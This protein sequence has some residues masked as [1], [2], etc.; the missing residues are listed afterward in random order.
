MKKVKMLKTAC[1][2]HGSFNS[3]KEY[4]IDDD[5]AKAWSESQDPACLII[6]V[7]KNEEEAPAPAPEPEPAPAPEP[8]PEPAPAPTP[9]RGKYRPGSK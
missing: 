1:G 4:S 7:S 2:P 5:L 6:E 8:E 3:G 9:R